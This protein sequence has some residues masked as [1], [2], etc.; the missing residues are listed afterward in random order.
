MADE[1]V[2]EFTGF[3]QFE[4]VDL[5][6]EIDKAGVLD[7]YKEVVVSIV[8]N[9]AILHVGTEDMVIDPETS[10]LHLR[11]TQEQTSGFCNGTAQIQVNILYESDERDVTAQGTLE[12]LGNL[13]RQVM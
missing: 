12:I 3:Y 5:D 4:T 6:V 7:D 11:L 13:Y 9:R 2:D 8:Q 1:T 10:T